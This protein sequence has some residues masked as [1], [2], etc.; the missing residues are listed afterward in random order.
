[1]MLNTLIDDLKEE[2]T[3]GA[4]QKEDIEGGITDFPSAPSKQKQTMSTQGGVTLSELPL[5]SE[6]T[7]EKES[8]ADVGVY[9]SPE[10][11]YPPDFF[12]K[13]E[14]Y[15]LI[16]IRKK[17][18]TAIEYLDALINN[19]D[20]E[21]ERNIQLGHLYSVM[22]K[23]SKTE[24]F[25]RD[26]ESIVTTI[27]ASLYRILVNEKEADK[28]YFIKLNSHVLTKLRENINLYEK[29]FDDIIDSLTEY[30]LDLV[31]LGYDADD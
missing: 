16:G 30:G 19:Y 25:N 29:S 31:D 7:G 12:E 24:D 21:L 18:K 9:I 6:L 20:D 5:F 14:T 13:T 15:C 26:F 17:L 4:L 10:A 8:E 1:M 28:I 22:R 27:T 23:I 11:L 3:S 2:E